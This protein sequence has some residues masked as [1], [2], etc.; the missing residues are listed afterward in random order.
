[1]SSVYELLSKMEQNFLFAEGLS[2]F[3]YKDRK[4]SE[5]RATLVECGF[6]MDSSTTSIHIRIRKEITIPKKGISNAIHITGWNGGGNFGSIGL[7]YV[8]IAENGTLK[9]L[10]SISYEEE[11]L[12]FPNISSI[13]NRLKTIID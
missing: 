12:Y 7:S 8:Y 9:E 3:A 5:I 1:M 13:V 4:L 11:C 10:S 6:S 2:P